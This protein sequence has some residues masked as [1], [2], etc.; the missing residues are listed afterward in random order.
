MSK[1]GKLSGMKPHKP[2]LPDSCKHPSDCRLPQERGMLPEMLLPLR[3]MLSSCGWPVLFVSMGGSGPDKLQKAA[4][5]SVMMVS[6]NSSAQQ[7]E[8]QGQKRRQHQPHISTR[9]L[10]E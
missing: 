8:G 1:Q 10:M 5:N 9:P 2:G 3:S 7:W 6:A 4:S